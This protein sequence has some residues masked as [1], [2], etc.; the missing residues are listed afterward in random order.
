VAEAGFKAFFSRHE[1]FDFSESAHEYR[2]RFLI[3]ALRSLMQ[4]IA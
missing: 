4:R 2:Q 1:G 3:V